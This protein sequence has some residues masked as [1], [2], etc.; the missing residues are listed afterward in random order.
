MHSLV[1]ISSVDILTDTQPGV[2]VEVYSM[3]PVDHCLRSFISV[4]SLFQYICTSLSTVSSLR[5]QYSSNRRVSILFLVK[6]NYVFKN[7]QF[8][9]GWLFLLFTFAY[10]NAATPTSCSLISYFANFLMIKCVKN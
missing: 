5:W 9:G 8:V 2:K 6:S 1:D 3:V 10:E 4:D 7:L